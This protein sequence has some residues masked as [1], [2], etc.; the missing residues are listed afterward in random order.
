MDLLRQRELLFH[1]LEL[2]KDVSDF[3]LVQVPDGGA[4][5]IIR[6]IVPSAT[7]ASNARC[8]EQFPLDD[9]AHCFIY[10]VENRVFYRTLTI[11]GL[12]RAAASD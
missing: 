1:Q 12:V 10:M 6:L 11:D 4:L 9:C 2:S 5:I 7:H 3:R 8:Q